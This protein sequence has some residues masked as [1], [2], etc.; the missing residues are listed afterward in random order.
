MQV[1]DA[2]YTQKVLLVLNMTDLYR[3]ILCM[4]VAVHLTAVADPL[5]SETCA[6]CLSIA[7]NQIALTFQDQ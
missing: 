6:Y 5:A 4:E 7:L 2:E 1:C 3:R